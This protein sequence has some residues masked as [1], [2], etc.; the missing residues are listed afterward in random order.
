VGPF[1]VA[2]DARFLTAFNRGALKK[3]GGVVPQN[4]LLLF[5]KVGLEAPVVGGAHPFFPQESLLRALF[6]GRAL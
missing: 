5:G 6:L 1:Y 4:A 3:G 2:P